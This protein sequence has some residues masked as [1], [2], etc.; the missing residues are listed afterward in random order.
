MRQV[1]RI[2][3]IQRR[4][5]LELSHA[6]RGPSSSLPL[7]TKPERRERQPGDRA[8]VHQQFASCSLARPETTGRNRLVSSPSDPAVPV[9]R[10]HEIPVPERMGYA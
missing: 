4:A 5:A 10:I 7:A 2:R 1:L 6:R 8:A 9:E 3:L